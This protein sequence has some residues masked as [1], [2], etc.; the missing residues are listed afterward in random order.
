MY[1]LSHCRTL[2][3]LSTQTKKN[4]K[5]SHHFCAAGHVVPDHCIFIY[6]HSSVRSLQDYQLPFDHFY[7][8]LRQL[9]LGQVTWKDKESINRL[10]TWK[11]LNISMQPSWPDL[12]VQVH[13]FETPIK[14]E[15]HSAVTYT[16]PNW[17]KQAESSCPDC[18]FDPPAW[19]W[20]FGSAPRETN[21][22]YSE[23]HKRKSASKI[24][25][26]LMISDESPQGENWVTQPLSILF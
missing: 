9:K 22:R 20:C 11:T 6:R 25:L 13:L 18:Q 4:N 3:S 12:R 16:P 5:D 15:K 19:P 26:S 1:S 17:G 21:T 7:I 8:F 14:S 23:T 10:T 2:R 24:L